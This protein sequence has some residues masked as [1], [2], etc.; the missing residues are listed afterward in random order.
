M[1]VK[2]L[3]SFFSEKTELKLAADI[4]VPNA[5]CLLIFSKIR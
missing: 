5:R 4:E 1:K 2:Q 3:V